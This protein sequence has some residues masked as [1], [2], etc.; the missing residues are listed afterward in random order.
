MQG[1]SESRICKSFYPTLCSMDYRSDGRREIDSVF[2]GVQLGGLDIYRFET[3]VS[4]GARRTIRH[5]R[6]DRI[7]GY[8]M[9]LPLR[10]GI[11][12]IQGQACTEVEPGSFAFISTS[13]PFETNCLSDLHEE[14]LI[15]VPG[16]LLRQRIPYIDD[17]CARSFE[18]RKGAGT[19]L[20]TLFDM[21][22]AD[23]GALPESC[24]L[25]F[26]RTVIETIASATLEAPELVATQNEHRMP[27]HE[28]IQMRAMEYIHNHIADPMLGIAE[29]ANHC[30]VSSRT[31]HA[32]FASTNISVGSFIREQRL[33]RC[34]ETLRNPSM[35]RKTIIEIAMTWG[36]SDAAHFS[37]LYK[38]RFGRTP[39]EERSVA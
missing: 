9:A 11:Q 38:A 4:R 7:D 30:K 25:L 16:S 39:R 6:A 22:L 35:R 3:Q 14:F 18:I 32:A 28:R 10:T 33:L 37:N 23:G 24:A 19:M 8:L 34:Q 36:F 27:A 15:K 17:C 29:I 20:R 1:L 21:A 12:I 5:V 13:K 31:L 26:G 2:E